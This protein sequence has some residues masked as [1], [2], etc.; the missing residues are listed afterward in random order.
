[1]TETPLS[2]DETA[3]YLDSVPT[4]DLMAAV[5]RRKAQRPYETEAELLA[6]EST[7]WVAILVLR[8][9]GRGAD[10]YFASVFGPYR[11]KAVAEDAR[12]TAAKNHRIAARKRRTDTILVKAEV[13]PAWKEPG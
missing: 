8:S 11:T 9:A 5:A 1:M 4:A 10:R 6:A 2:P 7:G 13:K 3:D 12:D